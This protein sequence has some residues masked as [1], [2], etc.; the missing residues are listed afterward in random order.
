MNPALSAGFFFYATA[1][2]QSNVSSCQCLL[3]HVFS[4]ALPSL[5][6]S[7]WSPKTCLVRDKVSCYPLCP[8]A[9]RSGKTTSEEPSLS[10]MRAEPRSGS[11]PPRSKEN[12]LCQVTTS[13]GPDWFSCLVWTIPKKKELSLHDNKFSFLNPQIE[14]VMWGPRDGRLMIPKWST[15]SSHADRFRIMTRTTR[16]TLLR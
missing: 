6:G 14:T 13:S 15:P 4:F 2:N 16:K 12:L 5:V 1:V 3:Q 11:G 8:L 7:F 10:I 9:G